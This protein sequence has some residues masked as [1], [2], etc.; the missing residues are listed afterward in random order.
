MFCKRRRWKKGRIAPG[1]YEENLE[2]KNCTRMIW[3]KGRIAPGWNKKRKNCTRRMWW[4][5]WINPI[6]QIDMAQNS[7]RGNELN[8][9]F[10]PNSSDDLCLLF[11]INPTCI[12]PTLHGMVAQLGDISL[13]FQLFLLIWLMRW[14]EQGKGTV[15]KIQGIFQYILDSDESL[16]VS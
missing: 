15:R 2:K 10:S 1:W 13:I 14:D 11:N 12:G 4:K 6:L 3:R 16:A 7:S 9:F 8:K 5:W